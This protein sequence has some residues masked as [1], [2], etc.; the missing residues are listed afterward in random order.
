MRLSSACL[1][2]LPLLSA[3]CDVPV[4]EH[5]IRSVRV[6]EG[7]AEDVW[8]R[9]YTLP[10]DGTLEIVGEDGA[11]HVRAADGSAGRGASRARSARRVATRRRARCSRSRRY[12]RK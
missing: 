1:S 5:G 12:R 8:S 4:D 9:T 7:R 10:A 6:A 2:R 11:I 3:A